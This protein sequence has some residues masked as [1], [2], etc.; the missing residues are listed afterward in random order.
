MQLAKE[1][2][3]FQGCEASQVKLEKKLGALLKAEAEA[4][5]FTNVEEAQ[6]AAVQ[7]VTESA[8]YGTIETIETHHEEDHETFDEFSVGIYAEAGAQHQAHPPMQ[9][10]QRDF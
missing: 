9:V 4:A 10:G 1:K 8:E 2:G 5:G 7:A 3:A 6:E